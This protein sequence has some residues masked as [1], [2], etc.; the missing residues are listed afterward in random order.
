MFHFRVRVRV[1][2]KHAYPIKL[3]AYHCSNLCRVKSFKKA[4]PRRGMRANALRGV[5]LYN[6][7]GE[8]FFETLYRAQVRTVICL[9]FNRISMLNTNPNPN[10]KMEHLSRK[11]L[12]QIL[13][14]L[15]KNFL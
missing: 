13:A 7:S 10:P 8:R 5:P 14:S 9:Q 1:S 3:Q 4:I 2:I 15:G 12:E 6:F 11:N